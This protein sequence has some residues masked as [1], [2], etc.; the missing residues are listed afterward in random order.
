MAGFKH[1]YIVIKIESKADAAIA[2][3]LRN[4]LY[5]SMK[6]NFGDFVLSAI[7]RFEVLESHEN[8]GIV[9]LRCNLGIY[10]YLCY[11]LISLGRFNDTNVRFS[12]L[13]SSGILKKAKIKLLRIME[14]DSK[15]QSIQ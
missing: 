2:S 4:L 9:I 6:T 11:T 10:K 12:I 3:N 15:R 13:V 7:D 5:R 1:R 8:L 14:C